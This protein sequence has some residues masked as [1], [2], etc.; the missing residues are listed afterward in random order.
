MYVSVFFPR[1]HRRSFRFRYPSDSRDNFC[2]HEGDM[3]Q[4]ID[5]VPV[6]GSCIGIPFLFVRGGGLNHRQCPLPVSLRAS[7]HVMSFR[8]RKLIGNLA[9]P[10]FLFSFDEPETW[11][12]QACQNSRLSMVSSRFPCRIFLCRSPLHR[13]DLS[14]LVRQS[15]IS[16][17]SSGL[18]N[19]THP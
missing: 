17:A 11:I 1:C 14:I 3:I 6:P 15:Y 13:G 5:P 8:V 2:L 19:R 18:F 7:G 12:C 10:V 9:P 4:V 16:V